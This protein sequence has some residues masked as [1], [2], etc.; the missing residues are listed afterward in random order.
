MA[1]SPYMPY[2]NI[3]L[4][5]VTAIIMNRAFVILMLLDCFCNAI[6]D[7]ERRALGIIT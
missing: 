1:E 3:Y 2:N 4:S 6:M 7:I 5:L